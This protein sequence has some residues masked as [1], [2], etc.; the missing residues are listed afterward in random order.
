MNLR[1]IGK[2][3]VLT[4]LMSGT[5]QASLLNFFFTT[6]GNVT[7]HP[8]NG[9][10]A[11]EIF[12]LNDTGTSVPTSIVITTDSLDS[13][14]T[15]NLPYTLSTGNGWTF[16]GTGF[17]VTGGVITAANLQV[18]KSN[19]LFYFNFGTVNGQ[20]SSVS[21]PTFDNRNVLGFP[22][23]TYTLASS[24]VPEPSQWGAVAVLLLIAGLAVKRFSGRALAHA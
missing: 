4:V 9:T 19:D 22:G 14:I 8:T 23:V 2:A 15:P 12:G 24:P 21:S 18:N 16:T 10:I 11:G 6:P 20:Q 3:L 1:T 7:T 17:T 13:L 5:S